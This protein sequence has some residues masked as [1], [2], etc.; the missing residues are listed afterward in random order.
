ILFLHGVPGLRPV[1]AD[2]LPGTPAATARLAAGDLITKVENVPIATWQ[3]LRWQLLDHAVRR[4]VVTLE[5]RNAK[6]EISFSHL[7]LSGL[8]SDD[9]DSGLLEAVGIARYNPPI[10][11]VIGKLIKGGAAQRDGLKEGDRITAIDGKPVSKWSEL[12]EAVRASPGRAIVFEVERGERRESVTVMTETVTEGDA[13]I[14]KIGAAPLVDQ[15]QIEHLFTEVRYSPIE[16]AWRAIA[17]TAEV[18]AFTLKMLGRMVV[19]EVSI[20]NLSGPI[21]I[22]DYAGQ[23]AQLGWL[24]YLNFLALISISLGV[25]NLLPVPVLDGGHLMYYL[26]EIVKGSPVSER[27]L[28]VGQQVGIVL[29]FSLMAF[30]LYNDINRL[31][32]G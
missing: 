25:L 19:G 11:P 32:G 13:V 30:A 20:K 24:A 28:E 22:A 9:I 14:G 7:D 23:T 15:K 21:T 5:V 29:L 10:A 2:A 16:S 3:D 27:A 18:S 4:G 12:V 6:G 1:I 17:R 8:K 31:F 26:V